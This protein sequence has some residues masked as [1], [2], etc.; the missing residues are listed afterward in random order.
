M[1]SPT[2]QSEAF[3][4]RGEF[5]I[6]GSEI[7]SG[8]TLEYNLDHVTLSLHRAL[9]KGR[10]EHAFDV[11]P[12]DAAPSVIHGRTS[13]RTDLTLLQSWYSR[14]QPESFFSS[15]LGDATIVSHIV[16]L[17]SH[18]LAPPAQLFDRC[19]LHIPGLEPWFGHTPFKETHD[20]A[21]GQLPTF[22]L[23][24]AFPAHA[25]HVVSEAFGTIRTSGSFSFLGGGETE[26]TVRHNVWIEISPSQPQSLPWFLTVLQRSERL[27]SLFF[28]TPVFTDE[29]ILSPV[30]TGENPPDHGHEDV[31]LFTTRSRESV[32]KENAKL[33]HRDFVLSYSQ[34]KDSLPVVLRTWFDEFGDLKDALNLFFSSWY[35]PGPFLE[36][37]FLPTIQSLEILSRLVH[38]SRYVPKAD[39]RKISTIVKAAI[40]ID[41]PDELKESLKSGIGFANEFKLSERLRRLMGELDDQSRFLFCVDPSKFVKGIVDTR[42]F[43]THYSDHYKTVLQGVDLHW[44]TQ[45]L[46]VLFGLALLKRAGFSEDLLRAAFKCHGRLAAERREWS[47]ITELGTPP[48]PTIDDDEW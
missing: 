10:G 2:C 38:K 46:R 13:D 40:P 4:L 28:G 47:K 11:R 9:H 26:I 25:E 24:C 31:H 12:E 1:T 8:G 19:K 36:T 39:F 45:K 14:W 22:G 17:G 3:S 34:V 33:R 35:Q 30:K 32:S 41:I 48:P 27:F 5:W 6:P 20:T 43:L 29:V 23:T 18:L 44:A 37:K 21:D 15:E 16:L 7:R 42:N